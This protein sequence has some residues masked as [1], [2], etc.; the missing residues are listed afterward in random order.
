MS[1]FAELKRRNVVK[2]GA[3]YLPVAG[4]VVQAASLGLPGFRHF[5]PRA[6]R[7]IFLTHSGGPSQL[8]LFDHK[9][10]LRQ[11]AG[12]EL[13]DSVRQGQRVTTMTAN[14]KQLKP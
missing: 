8:E 14:Q 11:W 4:P 5:A 10:G 1:L 3:A 6:K 13:P 7:V 12:K 2:V 9:P